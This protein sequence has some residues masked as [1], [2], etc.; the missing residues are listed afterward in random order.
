MVHALNGVSLMVR[1]GET[2][3]IIAGKSG[4]GKSTLARCLVRLYTADAGTVRYGKS[5]VLALHGAALRRHRR[6]V[7][8]IFQDPMARSI[9]A[10]P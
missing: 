6:R 1:R 9:H 5:D 3:E 2:L 4:C 7:Q 8:M 10:R